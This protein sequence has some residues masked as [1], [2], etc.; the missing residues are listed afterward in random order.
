MALQPGKGSKLTFSSMSEDFV[1][2]RF[3]PDYKNVFLKEN[4]DAFETP[5]K[6]KSYSVPVLFSGLFDKRS[7]KAIENLVNG[8]LQNA[9]F[10]NLALLHTTPIVRFYDLS[11]WRL[12]YD[13]E[14]GQKIQLPAA[15]VYQEEGGDLEI[16]LIIPENITSSETVIKTVRLLCAKLFGKLFFDE[17]IPNKAP[18]NSIKTVATPKAFDLSE[19]IHFCRLLDN[20]PKDI[21]REFIRIARGLG[22]RG[23]K[24]E[25]AGKKEFFRE[26]LDRK[27][28]A[29]QDHL[30]HIKYLFDLNMADA[31]ENPDHFFLRVV[32]KI[33]DLLPQSSIILPHEQKNFAHLRNE[34]QLSL[35]NALVD[36]LQFVTNGF[37][38]IFDCWSYLEKAGPD[39]PLDYNITDMWIKT[40][41]E[42][43]N[44]LLKR[45]GIKLF[46]I[47]GAELSENQK[48]QKNQFPLWIWQHRLMEGF[49]KNAKPEK[50]I[51]KIT[52]QYKHS[53][54]HKLFEL[55]YRLINDIR[56]MEKDERLKLSAV[57]DHV[58]LKSLKTW[59][60]LRSDGLS[61][62]LNSCKV[63]AV[64]SEQVNVNRENLE[65]TMKIYEKGWSYFIS[66]ALLHQYFLNRE[67]GGSSSENRAEHFFQL[68]E[69]Y[70]KER[71]RKH[72]SFR[73]SCLLLKVYIKTNFDLNSLVDVLTSESKI[74]DFFVLNQR[75]IIQKDLK[76][77]EASI[78]QYG[79]NI[80]K[81][82]DQHQL[83]QITQSE[84]EHAFSE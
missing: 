5:K 32:D 7:K 13:P 65:K 41:G 56:Q 4:I 70:I 82:L 78:E 44:Q 14:G 75:N 57:K 24:P 67:T 3:D 17:H 77:I 25:E 42:L 64:L 34:Q 39:N 63:G 11:S 1:D 40:L 45:G 62:L 59:I 53:I 47:D 74:L 51:K 52:D 69:T 71:I 29:S 38:E 19:K 37:Q 80:I 73:L 48:S 15:K 21:E 12:S 18:F 10:Y 76:N 58:K 50:V 54:Y 30:N 46:L 66:F 35:F 8:I 81:W 28:K 60:D 55:S 27:E 61:D 6:R 33:F 23:K 26:L 9:E 79:D 49:P 31:K 72:P 83:S 68:I 2:A 20:F 84:L 16:Q 43:K 22:I 36:R